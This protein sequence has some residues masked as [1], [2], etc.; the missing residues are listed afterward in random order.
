MKTSI[1]LL[2][3]YNTYTLKYII[4]IFQISN[5]IYVTSTSKINFKFVSK[6][7]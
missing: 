1:Q 2:D 5:N 3:N 4:I 7:I 6:K